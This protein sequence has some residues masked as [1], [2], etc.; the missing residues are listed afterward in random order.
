MIYYI[1]ITSLQLTITIQMNSLVT[2]INTMDCPAEGMDIRM[3]Q[4]YS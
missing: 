1:N 4:F 3:S 2:G